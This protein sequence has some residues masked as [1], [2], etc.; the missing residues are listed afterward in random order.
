MPHP[1]RLLSGCSAACLALVLVMT[2]APPAGA[3]SIVTPDGA[4]QGGSPP[5]G[6]HSTPYTGVPQFDI[7]EQ[8][9]Q[10]RTDKS[11]TSPAGSAIRE[12][13]TP[14]GKGTVHFGVQR[15][16]GMFGRPFGFGGASG[17]RAQEDRRHMNRMLAPPGLQHQYDFR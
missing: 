11:G 17:F 1:L 7:E 12:F 2:G 3:F 4:S 9:R 5:A 16:Y 13:D 6:G 8:M 15:D 10:F 14:F